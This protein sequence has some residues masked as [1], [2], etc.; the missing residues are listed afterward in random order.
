MMTGL[1]SAEIDETIISAK[2]RQALVDFFYQSIRPKIHSNRDEKIVTIQTYIAAERAYAQSD[3]AITMFHLIKI[4]Q[5]EWITTTR[6]TA[7]A[8]LLTL[9]QTI[10][11]IISN[12]KDPMADAIH[13]YAKRRTP[14]FLLLRD[15]FMEHSE[16][17]R[18]I[19]LSPSQLQSKLE[20]IASQ[21]YK[22]IGT[23]VRR[24]VV[25]SIIYLFLTKMVFAFLLEAPVDVFLFKRI[26]YIP[27]T[28]NALF[29]PFLL[30][31]IAGFSSIP[32]AD[33][34]KRLVD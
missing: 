26:D 8:H 10:E 16:H 29:P 12:M 4:M 6:D 2:K 31:L 11:S 7:E 24:A 15:L 14:P 13:R 17:L 20:E 34:T 9:T 27:L 3:E 22:L 1:A 18:A 33:N 5:P 30:F 32:G 23:K 21:K 25:R 28:I 19:V